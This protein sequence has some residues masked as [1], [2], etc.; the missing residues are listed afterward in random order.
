MGAPPSLI[1]SQNGWQEKRHDEQYRPQ[2]LSTPNIVSGES[3]KW[4]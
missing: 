3:Y 4:K 2:N 1:L